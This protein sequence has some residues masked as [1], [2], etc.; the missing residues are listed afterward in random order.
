MINAD[1]RVH[2]T[3]LYD[4]SGG[5]RPPLSVLA[6]EGLTLLELIHVLGNPDSAP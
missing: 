5:A 3:G 4:H 2:L 6:R 1:V